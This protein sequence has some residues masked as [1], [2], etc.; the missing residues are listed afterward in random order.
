MGERPQGEQE[1]GASR[2]GV[3]TDTCDGDP[4]GD[5]NAGE[6]EEELEGALSWVGL[7]YAERCICLAWMQGRPSTWPLGPSGG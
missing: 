5:P 3:M 4:N 2:D 6:D 7:G 1:A